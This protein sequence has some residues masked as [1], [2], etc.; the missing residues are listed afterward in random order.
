VNEIRQ[1][2]VVQGEG[3]TDAEPEGRDEHDE[4]VRE[5]AEFIQRYHTRAEDEFLAHGSLQQGSA[6]PRSPAHGTHGNDIPQ[7]D[8][9]PL[10]QRPRLAALR[11]IFTL[12]TTDPENAKAI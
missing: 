8:P 1:R 5:P 7:L 11:F 12:R 4:R 10:L 2:V 3:R 6:T 9:P